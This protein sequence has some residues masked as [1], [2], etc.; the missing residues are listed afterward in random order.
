M[1]SC[2]NVQVKIPIPQS[3]CH[4]SAA[5]FGLSPEMT[6]V[7]LFGGCPKWPSN[8]RRYADLPQIGDTAVLRFGEPCM[9]VGVC[10]FGHL[11]SPFGKGLLCV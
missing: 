6:E 5:S 3:R 1:F 4:H 11:I 9:H 8:A 2:V 10:A 7:I